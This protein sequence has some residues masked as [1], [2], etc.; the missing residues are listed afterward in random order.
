MK[1][2]LLFEDYE[3]ACEFY[4]TGL[5]SLDEFLKIESEYIKKYRLFIFCLN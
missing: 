4:L 2:N 3:I 1:L 5:Y